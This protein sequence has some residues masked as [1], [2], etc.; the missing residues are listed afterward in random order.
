MGRVQTPGSGPAR[1]FIV[2]QGKDGT[3]LREP[4]L[5]AS[6]LAS[7][8]KHRHTSTYHFVCVYAYVC[9]CMYVQCV[10]L[11]VHALI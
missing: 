4:L 11:L 8:W 2:R 1:P 7:L 3:S 5:C 6:A 10:G 9:I